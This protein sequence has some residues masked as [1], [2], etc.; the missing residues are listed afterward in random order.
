MSKFAIPEF[1]NGRV[2]QGQYVRWLHRK[3]AAHV[4]RDRTRKSHLIT[5]ADYRRLIHHAVCASNGRDF[6]TGE[7]LAW[8]K[9]STYSNEESRA[10]RSIYKAAFASLP[11]VDHVLLEDGTYDFVICAWRTNDAKSDL[12]HADFIQLCRS[13][14]THADRDNG[15]AHRQ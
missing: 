7:E 2:S 6:Y 13:V 12:S 10:N 9:V 1:L 15:G 11:T 14:I 8:E 5:G 3:A 4:K